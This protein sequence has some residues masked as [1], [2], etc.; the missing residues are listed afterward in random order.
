MKPAW[1]S[2]YLTQ[3]ARCY[4]HLRLN[5]LHVH[6]SSNLYTNLITL[7]VEVFAAEFVPTPAELEETLKNCPRLQT[8]RLHA[9]SRTS[10][11]SSNPPHAHGIDNLI[12][13][14]A[15]RS[16]DLS[17]YGN[18]ISKLS[19]PAL[20]SLHLERFSGRSGPA[21]DIDPLLALLGRR[22][23]TQKPKLTHL[24]LASF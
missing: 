9:A 18:I 22:Y 5:N 23:G 8:L 24:S 6:W 7:D 13:L 1:H 3:R 15:L 20:E 14:P 12:S 11:P 19:T 2:L 21:G 4:E 17:G 10:R 16:I